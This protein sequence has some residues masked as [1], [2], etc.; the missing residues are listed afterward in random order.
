MGSLHLI[1][2]SIRPIEMYVRI[3]TS[4]NLFLYVFIGL[5]ECVIYSRANESG[6]P[7]LFDLI[8]A[9]ESS[10]GSGEIPDI[11]SKINFTDNA[12]VSTD[13]MTEKPTEETP[14]TPETEKPVTEKSETGKP[15]T[16]KPETGKP[17]IETPDNAFD[18]TE[19]N[20]STEESFDLAD[21]AKELEKD[22]TE[23]EPPKTKNPDTDPESTLK[24]NSKQFRLDPCILV[25]GFLVSLMI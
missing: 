19:E 9:M 24:S 20:G 5:L 11:S 1:C 16:G 8:D 13:F 15:E 22:S 10:G 21:L 7:D 23:T 17:E 4:K 12:N 3:N 18:D 2:A 6:E 14:D 25:F